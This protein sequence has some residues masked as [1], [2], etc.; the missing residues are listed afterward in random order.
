MGSVQLALSTGRLSHLSAVLAAVVCLFVAVHVAKLMRE[1]LSTTTFTR[2]LLG[3]E[4]PPKEAVITT[5][6]HTLEVGAET[7]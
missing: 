6:E 3:K 2:A 7:L 5:L 4:W 1:S